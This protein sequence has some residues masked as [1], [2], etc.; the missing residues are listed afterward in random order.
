MQFTM[1]PFLPPQSWRMESPSAWVPEQGQ[2]RG[3]PPADVS[4]LSCR[5]ENTFE[6]EAI[7]G[8]GCGLLQLI[9]ASPDAYE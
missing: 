7:E 5:K 8:P 4:W 9:L 2:E 3:A 6:I 1:L